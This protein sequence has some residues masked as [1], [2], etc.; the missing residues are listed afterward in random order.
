M[1]DLLTAQTKK[2]FWFVRHLRF[3]MPA[4]GLLL[5][6]YAF[7][8]LVSDLQTNARCAEATPGPRRSKSTTD[9]QAGHLE[10]DQEIWFNSFSDDNVLFKA[11]KRLKN[12]KV[13]VLCNSGVTDAGIT[14]LS[15]FNG[16][17]SLTITR[18]NRVS[19]NAM[20]A[21]G[22][23]TGLIELNVEGTQFKDNGLYELRG[24]SKLKKLSMVDCPVTGKGFEGLA[25]L[26]I[27]EL[28]LVCSDITDENIANIASISTIEMLDLTFSK[29]TD[30]GVR[31]LIR[32]R[33]LKCLSLF[34][35]HITNRSFQ[36]FFRMQSLRQ[37]SIRFTDTTTMD[38]E[39]MSAT[40]P[41]LRLN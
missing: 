24:L 22:K 40:M 39:A 9:Y 17:E 15:K 28:S 41:W 5:L 38:C 16:I 6:A 2:R 37:L 1:L 19:Q 7:C 20:S 12:A 10:A 29:V 36:V 23:M 14:F 13:V 32:L 3:K 26:P 30:R 35:T 27:K 4:F 34:G 25:T 21:I 33:H 31:H 11:A 8:C 18:C